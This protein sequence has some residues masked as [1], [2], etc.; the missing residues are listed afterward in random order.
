MKHCLP[1]QFGLEADK[2]TQHSKTLKSVSHKQISVSGIAVFAKKT[3]SHGEHF[4]PLAISV[5]SH[6]TLLAFSNSFNQILSSIKL[7]NL[8]EYTDHT[9][10]SIWN[11]EAK[12]L[13]RP[14]KMEG[15]YT[16]QYK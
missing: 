4:F 1:G 13:V 5:P 14:V 10:G 2:K 9:S 6:F 12:N 16:K 15:C 3:Q 7:F 11:C 8:Q